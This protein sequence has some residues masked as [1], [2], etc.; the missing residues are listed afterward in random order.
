MTVLPARP[1]GERPRYFA[2]PAIDKVL[3]IALALAG[4]VAVLR[5]RLD[6]AERLAEQGLPA[7]RAA[8]DAFTPDEAVR[9]ERDA[10]RDQFLDVVLRPVHQEREA[11]AAAAAETGYDAAVSAVEAD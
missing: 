6:S 2:E 5:D 4:E 11:L 7:T 3:G 10:W 1:K 9:A 8:I